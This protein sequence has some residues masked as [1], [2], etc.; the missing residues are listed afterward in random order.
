MRDASVE[1]RK[2][3]FN[4]R[5]PSSINFAWPFR[6]ECQACTPAHVQEQSKAY[7]LLRQYHFSAC[8]LRVSYMNYFSAH[9]YC[10]LIST[11]ESSR[12]KAVVLSKVFFSNISKSWLSSHP[13]N[14]PKSKFI[15][16][17]KVSWLFCVL[18]QL[19]FLFSSGHWIYW[20]IGHH[21]LSKM[22]ALMRTL[23]V[24]YKRGGCAY[25]I[26]RVFDCSFGYESLQ[27]RLFSS[28]FPYHSTWYCARQIFQMKLYAHLFLYI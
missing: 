24:H 19:I 20:D 5:F 6:C 17:F 2:S 3:P 21:S 27:L 8:S 4:L 15:E 10:L 1:N 26:W 7:K 23:K 22:D 28:H 14:S 16:L 18:K 13:E 9:N 11:F 12:R 25:C